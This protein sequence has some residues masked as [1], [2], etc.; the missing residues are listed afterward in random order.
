[1]ERL[2]YDGRAQAAKGKPAQAV[3]AIVLGG[4]LQQ[5]AGS[6]RAV[7]NEA[8]IALDLAGIGAIVMD[9]VRVEGQRR[10]AEQQPFVWMNDALGIPVRRVE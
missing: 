4:E 5:Q 9:A 8:A 2:V 6:E 3:F 7:D 1:M 10:I